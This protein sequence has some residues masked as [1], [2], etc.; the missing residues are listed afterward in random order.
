MLIKQGNDWEQN[1][2]NCLAIIFVEWPYFKVTA[3]RTLIVWFKRTMDG[4]MQYNLSLV[5]AVATPFACAFD[6]FALGKRD[7][8]G[9]WF[10]VKDIISVALIASTRCVDLET[11]NLLSNYGI[12]S[13]WLFLMNNFSCRKVRQ[14]G[15]REI[16]TCLCQ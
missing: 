2:R 16:I 12:F 1:V 5:N 15:F 7:C 9:I 10:H 14:C 4:T 13:C 6:F 3:V 8:R 11:I